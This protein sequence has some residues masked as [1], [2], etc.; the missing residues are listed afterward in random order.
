MKNVKII[1]NMLITQCVI[2]KSNNNDAN[3]KKDLCI[4]K[5]SFLLKTKS[6][7]V[8]V[9]KIRQLDFF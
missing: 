8:Q 5:N 6:H 4:K 7:E 3:I 1:N 9:C 2:I